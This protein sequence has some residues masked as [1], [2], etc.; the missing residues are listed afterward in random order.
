MFLQQSDH[1]FSAAQIEAWAAESTDFEVPRAE[2]ERLHRVIRWYFPTTLVGLDN[3]PSGP[4]LFVGN[5]SLYGIDAVI[6]VT[7]MLHGTGRFLRVTADKFFFQVGAGDFLRKRGVVLANPRICSALM[8]AGADVVV[9]PGGAYESTK[10]ESQKYA[11]RWRERYGFVRM[12]ALH[13]YS[14]TP[15]AMVGPDDCFRHLIEGRALLETPPF[16]F[17]SRLG[18]THDLRRDILPPLP[19]GVYGTLLPKPQ[20]AFAA[21]GQP[22]AVP[23]CDDGEVPAAVL[24]KTRR[25]TAQ[26]IDQ[27]LRDMLSLRAS[28]RPG[29]PRRWFL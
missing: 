28:Q 3:I 25:D 21:F 18:L 2:F 13:G 23:R 26:S 8:E 5:H 20:P 6:L 19:A 12:A 16:R 1:P 17:L 7:E 22:L 4:T 9:Y 24:R 27:L 15:F 14:I 10:P 29:W 11:L